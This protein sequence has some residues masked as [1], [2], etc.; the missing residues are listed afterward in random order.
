MI[1][2]GSR[3]A[4]VRCA[5]QVQVRLS[6]QRS[7]AL[8]RI[9]APRRT[10]NVSRKMCSHS[11]GS[12]EE[13][14]AAGYRPEQHCVWRTQQQRQQ[15]Q[16]VWWSLDRVQ[17]SMRASI[18][19][20]EHVC[21]FVPSVLAPVHWPFGVYIWR[22]SWGH[23]RGRSHRIV[24]I[25]V[26]F[27][28]SARVPHFSPRQQGTRMEIMDALLPPPNPTPRFFGRLFQFGQGVYFMVRDSVVLL[29]SIYSVLY[30]LLYHSI[31]LDTKMVS[32]YTY[33]HTKSCTKQNHVQVLL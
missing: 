27:M 12:G 13:C 10:P 23:A 20:L 14:G 3:S 31:N 16:Y 29:K 26:C 17:H 2:G 6:A 19:R 22:I 5:S 30:R 18:R 4:T 25:F 8:T 21:E 11:A 1:Q 7:M 28:P 15:N 9:V 24:F 33:N 32:A